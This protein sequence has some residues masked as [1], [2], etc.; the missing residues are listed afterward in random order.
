MTYSYGFYF[1]Q[2]WWLVACVLLVGV[3]WLGLR[4]LAALG[5][6]RRMLSIVLRCLVVLILILLLARPMLTQT[7]KRL[8]V[9][10]VVDRSQSIP[11]GLQTR[12]VNYLKHAL[13]AKD[14]ED[15]VA[16]V[17]V[18]EVASISQLPS[19]KPS[20]RE[21]NT[22]LNGQQ[23]R[24]SDGVQ[25]AMAIAPPDTAVR[26]LLVSEGNETA[27][28]L[29]EAARLAAANG[30][31]IDVLP[32]LYRYDH[33]VVF[34]RL[35]APTK[36]RSG[37]TVSLRFILNSTAKAR[38]RLMLNL[39]GKPVDLDPGSDLIA[40]PVELEEGTNVRTISVPVG[41]RGMHEF[42]AVFMPEDG[43]QDVIVE[44][45][46]ATAITYVA[47]PGHALVVDADGV[48]KALEGSEI[49]V[50][51]SPAAAFPDNLA[52]L[53]DTDAIILVNTDCSNFTFQ[54]QEMLVR[55]VNDIGGGLIMVGGPES[56]G[57]GGWMGSPV[58]EI[59]PVD[60]DPPQKKEMPKGA[61]VLIMHACEMPQ[62]NF[63]GKRVAISA[64]NTLSKLD[65]V[66]ILAYNWKGSGD[67]VYPLSPVG[68]KEAVRSA[69]QQMMMG[70][71]P[72]RRRR[73]VFC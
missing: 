47:G 43:G 4:S 60:L 25:M 5:R 24:L 45:N 37:Q 69:I 26:I 19:I 21:R 33:E 16:V 36:A 72:T 62:G 14:M 66:G 40:V 28:D 64:V 32:L 55:Y 27:G 18:A 10:T 70:D 20:V 30:I 51:Y 44:N 2:P 38:G 11:A 13:A 34:R 63:W 65:L 71:M 29:K 46:R 23:T 48:T 57:A 53:M 31:P 22:T 54:Q 8:T 7:S 1:G 35:A 50:R 61:L 59:L 73:A 49:D 67:W 56:F 58:E 68:D 9:I 17:D 12:S 52:R 39:N 6:T 3:V 41:S 42:E 15:R